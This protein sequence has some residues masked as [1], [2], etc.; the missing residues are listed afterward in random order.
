MLFFEPGV[1]CV[2]IETDK[3]ENKVERTLTYLLSASE[4]EP[5][6]TSYM[7]L[8]IKANDCLYGQFDESNNR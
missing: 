1:I 6:D 5:R 4:T 2:D 3:T 7:P 8:R